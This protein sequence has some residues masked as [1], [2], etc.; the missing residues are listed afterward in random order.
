MLKSHLFP[1]GRIRIYWDGPALLA[2]AHAVCD[3]SLNW[4]DLP[5]MAPR[6]AAHVW[7]APVS[8]PERGLKTAIAAYGRALSGLGVD[9]RLAPM[10]GSATEC[11]RCGHGWDD[12]SHAS[13]LALALAVVEDAMADVW[14]AAFIF[15]APPVVGALASSLGRLFPDKR[16]ARVTLGP[17]L[18]RRPGALAAPSL[19]LAAIRLPAVVTGDDGALIAQP[20]CWRPVAPSR[21]M[22][23]SLSPS[24]A[25]VH[26]A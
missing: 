11:L 18:Q 23:A 12:H 6:G 10:Q 7:I 25:L 17:A 1:S 14:D 16:L 13:E 4:L 2:H 8:P 9:C 22:R 21:R 20:V 19:H 15:A 26:P 24:P 3:P 5:A